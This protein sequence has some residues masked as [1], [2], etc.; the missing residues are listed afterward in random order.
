VDT[1]IRRRIDLDVGAGR[2]WKDA[3]VVAL[4]VVVVGAFVAQVASPPRRAA[5]VEP[6]ARAPASVLRVA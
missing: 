1:L 4:L 6:V 3:A 5:G 2:G